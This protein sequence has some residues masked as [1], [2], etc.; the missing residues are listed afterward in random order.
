MH[1]IH[2]YTLRRPMQDRFIESTRGVGAPKP[3][4]FQ[5]PPVSP[6]VLRMNLLGA[7]ILGVCAVYAGW[8]FGN[9]EH[10]WAIQARSAILVYSGL[11]SAGLL[12]LVAAGR[13]RN[14]KA[15]LPFRTGIYVF[16]F[17]LIDAKT[18]DFKVYPATDLVDIQLDG[19]IARMKF[20]DGALFEFQPSDAAK[21][22]TVRDTL[23]QAQRQ[24]SLPPT[25]STLRDQALLDPLVDTGFK[26]LFAS[27]ESLKP[28]S[29]KKS[30]LWLWAT[31][32]GGATAGL[33]LWYLHNTLSEK[34]IYIKARRL[35]TPE[36]YHA[37]LAR[38]GSRNDVLDLLL[39]RAELQKA[40]AAGTSD[41][42]EHFMDAHSQS[43]IEGE[44]IGALQVTLLNELEFARA[45][46]TVSALREFRKDDPRAKLVESD[47][48]FALHKL[49]DA[50]LLRYQNESHASAEQQRMFEQLLRYSEQHGPKVEVR[51]Q[52]VFP[53]SLAKAEGK[54]QSSA[55]FGGPKALPLQYLQGV[56]ARSREQR[57]ASAVAK[58]V[59]TLFS[60]DVLNFE[61]TET[62]SSS[63]G[64]DPPKVGVPT[65]FINYKIGLSVPLTNRR[66][67]GSF[68]GL[69]LSFKGQLLIP[70][71]PPAMAISSAYWLPPNFKKLREGGWG[72]AELYTSM[73]D[74]ALDQFIE[75]Y[76][77]SLFRSAE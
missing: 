36:A 58:R 77:K 28:P 13:I 60:D 51:F 65:L 47:R 67:P 6:W 53:E 62:P 72:P 20:K 52:K 48:R 2:F 45:K 66:P 24:L 29:A 3:L 31:L 11:M 10:H 19:L 41:A 43:K 64:D 35:N 37:Y 76:L 55:Y 75:K 44:A 46:G 22:A 17:G 32:L 42:I 14:R 49:F 71:Q 1:P 15:G 33:G 27:A 63:S 61:F 39:P 26:S 7:V 25:E 9:L 5:A 34:Q 68:V 21:V 8:G 57:A 38:G 50:A 18:A 70:G 59:G 73:A 69:T 74:Q 30:G 40:R 4:L 16:P 23:Q 56:P 54:L 12:A